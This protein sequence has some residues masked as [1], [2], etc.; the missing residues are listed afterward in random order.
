MLPNQT[1]ASLAESFTEYLKNDFLENAAVKYGIR[2]PIE[3]VIYAKISRMDTVLLSLEMIL[4]AELRH[5]IL[6]EKH[7]YLHFAESGTLP[8]TA[9]D[10]IGKKL[11]CLTAK[12]L[13]A[14]DPVSGKEY[15]L[16]KKY[17][18]GK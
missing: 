13:T 1:I 17:Q 6:F 3:A 8:V 10:L 7:L 18:K 14:T 2:H 9:R 16:K 5:K 12:D 4:R 11:S 15:P